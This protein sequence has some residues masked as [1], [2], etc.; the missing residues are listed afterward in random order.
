M[1]GDLSQFDEHFLDT[2]GFGDVDLRESGFGRRSSP[3]PDKEAP[4]RRWDVQDWCRELA[5]S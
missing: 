4:R 2:L 3:K 1:A 5:F